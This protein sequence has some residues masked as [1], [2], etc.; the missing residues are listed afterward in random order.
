MFINFPNKTRPKTRS[1]HLHKNPFVQ[2]TGMLNDHLLG[3]FRHG[4]VKQLS[5]TQPNQ[6][7]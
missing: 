3:C 1:T 6:E 7:S 5:I 2:A 4:Q